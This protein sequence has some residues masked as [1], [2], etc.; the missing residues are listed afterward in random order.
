[1]IMTTTIISI[2]VTPRPDLVFRD[3]DTRRFTIGGRL[4]T[5]P[6]LVFPTDDIRIDSVSARLAIRAVTDDVRLISVLAGIA[7]DVRVSPR[8]VLDISLQIRSL[9]RGDGLGLHAQGLKT[10]L[11]CREN[12]GVE[13]VRPQRR[14]VSVDLCARR[15]L[16]GPVRLAQHFWQDQRRKQSDDRYHHHHFDKGPARLAA[17]SSSHGH[18]RILTPRHRSC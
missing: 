7:V 18:L 4:P 5:C 16:A 14:Q 12:A 1:M 2:S 3:P 11:S 17:I 10:L 8:I 9:P 15:G 6:T 13:F